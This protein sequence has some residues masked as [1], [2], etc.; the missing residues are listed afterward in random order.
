MDEVSLDTPLGP[1]VG[2]KTAAAFEKAFG[3]RAV[4]D[5]LGHYPRRYTHHGE[6]TSIKYLPVGE[7]VTIVAQ[8]VHAQSRSMKNRRGSLLEVIITDGVGRLSLTF[9]SQPWRMNDLKPGRRGI[10][11]GKV[12]EFRNTLQLAHPDYELFPEDEAVTP[13]SDEPEIRTGHYSGAPPLMAKSAALIPDLAAAQAWVDQPLPIYPATAQVNSWTIQKTMAL[14]LKQVRVTETLSESLL[15]D[16]Q[17]LP[18]GVSLRL[19]HQPGSDK[20]WQHA[21]ESLRFREALH[22]QLSLL[23]ERQ[24]RSH[25]VAIARPRVAS[26]LLD[27][28]DAALPFPLT[29]DQESVGAELSAELS[30]ISPM[31][32]LLQ[33]EVGSGK[34]LVALRA[35]LQ[36]AENGGQSALLAPTEVLASQHLRS[37]Q[38]SLGPELT[39][40]LQP[41][42]ITG[43]MPAKERRRALLATAAGA[44]QIVIGTHALLTETTT[45]SDLG[46]IVVDEQHRFGV[47]QREALRQKAEQ[48]PPHVL[49]MTA[50]PIPRTVALTTFGDLE[51]SVIQELPPGRLGITTHAVPTREH[52]QWEKRAWVRAAEE[53]ALGRQVYVVCPAI[54]PGTTEATPPAGGASPQEASPA[55]GHPEAAGRPALKPLANVEDTLGE[56]A[57]EPSLVGAR[58]EALTGAMP[59]AEKDRVMT[60]FAAGRVDILVATTVIEVGVNVPNAALMIVRDAERFGV[61]Q[62]HQLRGRVGRG[63]VPGLCLLITSAAPGSTAR[64]RVDQVASTT[65]GFKLAEIDLELRKEGDILGEAQSGGRSSLRLLRVLEDGELIAHT[66]GIAAG[67]LEADPELAGL[68]VLRDVLN[69]ER[70]HLRVQNLAKS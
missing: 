47:E 31:H 2:A 69:R 61:S 15:N 24:R 44:A 52:P 9:F 32:R 11:A 16:E 30:A 18:L 21:R 46:L 25:E 39:E 13:L 17:L 56:L 14:V 57:Q 55:P 70:D 67:L 40:Q 3:Y 12:T 33:G 63:S 65:D 62:L 68:P 58:I 42:L 5:L 37:I 60:E 51:V 38:E 22:L 7:H 36:V 29:G 59:A 8:V 35:M 28:F 4:G 10:F 54:A 41:V 53:I 6:L 48:T 27:R 26:G 1:V 34:T 50:T 23:R 66:R 49:V 20:E 19:I 43:Q 64:T 45:F